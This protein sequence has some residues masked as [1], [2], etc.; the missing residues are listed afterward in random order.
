MEP[1]TAISLLGTFLL[2][3]GAAVSRLQVGTCSECPHCRA[4][5]TAKEARE[6]AAVA[7]LDRRWDVG[8]CPRCGRTGPHDHDS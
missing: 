2:I 6:R 7:A 3:V 1:V 8:R 4:E 5:A